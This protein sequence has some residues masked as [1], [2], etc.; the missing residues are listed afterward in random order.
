[1]PFGSSFHS[2]GGVALSPT[3]RLMLV[4][5]GMPCVTGISRRSAATP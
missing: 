2:D 3:A 5:K 1:M 4:N